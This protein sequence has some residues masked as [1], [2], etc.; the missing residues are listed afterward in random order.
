MTT[1]SAAPSE[2]AH[3]IST[4]A[5]ARTLA[6]RSLMRIRR[7]PGA[8]VP[9][10][11]M[12]VF[13]LISFS[14]AFSSVVNIPG[15]PTDSILSWVAP[16]AVIQGSAFAGVGAS[17]AVASDLENGFYDRLLMSPSSRFSLMLGPLSAAMVRV[18][19]PFTVVLAVA[20]IGGLELT[21]GVRGLLML[22][23]TAEGVA[24]I[25]TFYGLALVYKFRTQRSGSLVQVGIF[26][27]MFLSVGQVP[28]AVMKGWLHGVATLNPM[29]NILRM[30]RQG[31][32]DQITWADTWPGLLVILVGTLLFGRWAY[33]NLLRLTEE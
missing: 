19:L 26:V 14:G 18:L 17:Q 16:Y 6:N 4:V 24:L 22:L 8:I 7:I 25:A 20:A 13:L 5:V 11:A 27:V 33:R 23:L 29:T 12:P 31:F 21:E 2:V 30:A 3:H 15:F 1:V 10:V 9:T 28:L 32:V